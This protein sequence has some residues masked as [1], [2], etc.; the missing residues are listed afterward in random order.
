MTV[1]FSNT[2]KLIIAYLAAF[3]ALINTFPSAEAQNISQVLAP[4]AENVEKAISRGFDYLV[5]T[6]QDDGS[7]P[8]EYGGSAGV[9]SLVGM[10]FLAAGHTPG[11]GVYGHT[12]DKCLDYVIAQQNIEG[13][14]FSSGKKDRGMYSHHIATL[15]LSEV[16]GMVAP[17]QE[18]KVRDSIGRAV[19]VIL[20]S[21][22]VNKNERDKGGWRYDP[23]SGDSDLSVSGWALMALRSAR[24]NG[25]KIPEDNIKKAIEYVRR[26]QHDNGGFGY[27]S[28]GEFRI[29][30]TGLGILCLTLTGYHD[31][32]EVARAKVFLEKH[33]QEIPRH[34]GALYSTYYAAQAAFQLGGETWEKVSEWL[35]S[36]LLP[37]Q[38]DDGSW[39]QD[40]TGG[41]E[42]GTDVYN[43]AMI[44]LALAVP[45]RQLPIYQR[46][47]TVDE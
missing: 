23:N 46:D 42:K 30:L 35:Y 26:M 27:Q 28:P 21:Q 12:I 2:N 44:I 25:A 45:Y 9:V 38:K 29:S 43:T 41:W 16:S 36:N 6:Q 1:I 11:I 34:D 24:L 3:I 22:N 8:G 32:E 37:K 33:F 18:A 5:A 7:F 19:R 47:E 4:H 13:Y 15:F 40:V 31:S 10:S 17:E 14:I 39:G 20:S